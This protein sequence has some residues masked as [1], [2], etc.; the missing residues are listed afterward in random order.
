MAHQALHQTKSLVES[1]AVKVLPPKPSSSQLSSF[2][3]PKIWVFKKQIK[4]TKATHGASNT[5]YG[6]HS[7]LAGGFE[8][9]LVHGFGMPSKISI[10]RVDI[11]LS[12]IG[13]PSL[14]KERGQWQQQLLDDPQLA[15]R[16]IDS[17][18]SSRRSK[19]R[20]RRNAAEA[21]ELD[22]VSQVFGSKEEL[23][24]GV[25]KMMRPREEKRDDYQEEFGTGSRTTTPPTKPK[26]RCKEVR[27]H[28]TKSK[29]HQ[30]EDSDIVYSYD[31]ANSIS[32]RR[33]KKAVQDLEEWRKDRFEVDDDDT[34]VRHPTIPLL[35]KG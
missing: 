18:N 16:E 23:E 7:A 2:S 32:R 20:D 12:P 13:L 9:I 27:K 6:W 31:N 29:H 17:S 8:S 26:S 15:E 34:R 3:R 25:M 5:V 19:E 1:I 24:E 10:Y 4:I 30:D 28:S 11:Y 22:M 33:L 35:Q 21:K 14:S